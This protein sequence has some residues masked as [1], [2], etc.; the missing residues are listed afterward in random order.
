METAYESQR[1]KLTIYLGY[2]PGVGKTYEMLSNAIDIY[3]SGADVKIGYIEPHQRPETQ[4][5]TQKLPMIQTKSQ[6]FGS[7]VFQY[8]DVDSIIE[9]SPSIVL[10]D[11]L[12]HTNIT[13]ERHEKRYM[14]IEEILAHGIDVHTTL[15]IQHIE[16]LSEQIKLMT[17]VKVKECVPDQLIMSA[18]AL[19]VVDLSPNQLIKR[20][21]AGKVYKKERLET[22][23]SNF[24]K[25][26]NLV[27]LRELT[28]RTAA[29]IMSEKEQLYKNKHTD[30][31]PHVAVAISG[32][33][34]NQAVIREARRI[35]NK[36]HARFTAIYID[37]FDKSEQPTEQSKSVH[38][39]LMLAQ[40]LGADVKVVYDNQIAKGLDEW[41]KTNHVTRLII[42]QHV[43]QKWHDRLKRPLIDRLMTFHHHYK[44]E[45]VPIEHIREAHKPKAMLN[46]KKHT[47]FT[48]DIF[49]MIFIQ[50]V[51]VLIGLWIY[52][53]DKGE[54]STVILLLFLIGIIVLSIWTQSYMI[55]F[56]A[57]ILNVLV[58]NY[59]FTV[60][61]FTFE[62]YR[63]DYPVTFAVSIL[64]SMLTSG[65]LKQIKHQYKVTKRQL[66]RTD[67]L[68]Q[69]N[70][71]IKNMYTIPDLLKTAGHQMQQLLN[72]DIIVYNVENQAVTEVL[73]VPNYTQD[74]KQENHQVLSWIIKNQRRAGVTTNTFPGIDHLY[75]PI[76][77]DPVKGIVAIRFKDNQVIESYDFS[78]LE[79]MLNEI[80]L[81]VENVTLM[82]KSR[83]SMLQAERETTRSNFLHSISHDIRTPLTTII[84][85][86]EML[87]LDDSN[88][89]I[90]EQKELVKHSYEEA[91][92]LH[93]LVSNILSLTRLERS[94]V[95]LQ[96]QTYLVDELVEEFEN[97][98]TRRHQDTLITVEPLEEMC[99]VEMD[100]KLILQ[101]IF[102]L[103]ENAL[104]YTPKKT[105][106]TLRLTHVDEFVRFEVIDQGPGVP[107]HEQHMMFQPFYTSQ[108]F[109]DNKKDS[110]GLGLYLVQSILEKHRSKLKYKSNLPHGSIFYFYL[111]IKYDQE[112]Q[113]YEN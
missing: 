88:I 71:S 65:L 111:P 51:S 105:P 10:I 14:D 89:P 28:L 15:N 46:P 56:L 78:I 25:Y 62:M 17:G 72:Q 19:E 80:S 101:A 63:F 49:K 92:Y 55:G 107:K 57:A 9:E 34:Y 112:V 64:V 90:E 73:R 29:D 81:A 53:W 54:S 38:R 102:N 48:I 104:K 47:Q 18:D 95:E 98:I 35:A 33:V 100:S 76:G 26:E 12:A 6:N 24:F 82:R 66:Y 40:S 84:G 5:L 103:I 83:A 70:H 106:I 4:A 21:K 23:F 108:L 22:A 45:I 50:T 79:S 8:V 109:K 27:E 68:L 31:T 13:K 41:C 61:R 93:M 87:Q 69:F 59:F 36:T 32:S 3:E 7:H 97:V 99:F 94:N 20:L 60:P 110:L 91:Q 42:G 96:L 30:I 86:L 39:H 1:G 58:F 74:T 37:S 113:S 44:I 2:S 67:I 11:E 52:T 75:L 16:S 77:T 85:N 43:R